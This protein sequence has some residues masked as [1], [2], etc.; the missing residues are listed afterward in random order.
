M[1][2]GDFK[3]GFYGSYGKASTTPVL[4]TVHSYKATAGE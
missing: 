3:F 1:P 4:F 2:G